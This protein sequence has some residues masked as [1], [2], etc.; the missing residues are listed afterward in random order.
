[1]YDPNGNFDPHNGNFDG[2][3]GFQLM[4]DMEKDERKMSGLKAKSSGFG[5]L[6][7]LIGIIFCFIPGGGFLLGLL[8]FYTA[9]VF[10]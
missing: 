8:C 3:D 9:W 6:L 4:H 5:T 10:K 1:M 2:P 7:I